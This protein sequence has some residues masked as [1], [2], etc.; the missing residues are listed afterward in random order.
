MRVLGLCVASCALALGCGD[1]ENNGKPGPGAGGSA[2]SG[3][4]MAVAGTG[5][6]AGSDTA[7]SDSGGTDSAGGEAAL[8]GEAGQQPVDRGERV[9]LVRDQVPNKLDLLMMI[10]NSI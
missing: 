8:G 1:T 6:K 4:D 5:N 10:D 2:G 7:G 9:E 3:G